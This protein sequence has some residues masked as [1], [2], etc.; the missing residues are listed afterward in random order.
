MGGALRPRVLPL[1]HRGGR[2][3]LGLLRCASG[4]LVP[5]WLVGVRG[6][7]AYIELRCHS[8]FSFG[9]GACTPEALVERAATYGYPALG[10]T[11]NA[12]LGGVIR[13][14]RAAERA[15]IRP[16]V[17]AELIV[18]GYPAAFL[19]MNEVGFQNLASLVT[20][21]RRAPRGDRES[22]V[23]GMGELVRGGATSARSGQ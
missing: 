1:R 22:V 14:V 20:Q 5:A 8:A 15:G 13:F 12:D 16:V 10:L 18:D 2:S 11:D 6:T 4:D 21:A 3:H 17:G 19:A 7:M 23:Q 9:D